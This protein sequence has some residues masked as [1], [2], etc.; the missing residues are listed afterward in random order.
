MKLISSLK[1]IDPDKE[2]LHVVTEEEKTQLQADLFEMMKDVAKICE[3]NDIKWSLSGGS[4]LGAVRHHGFIPWDDDMDI[5]MPRIEFEKFRKVFPGRF[6]DK[7]ELRVPGDKNYIF[8]SPQIMK[9]NTVFKSLM[10]PKNSDQ[11]I[12]I[13]IFLIENLSNTRFKYFIH[14]LQCTALYALQSMVRVYKC[15]DNLL[16]HTTN[17]PKIRRA[18]KFRAFVGMILSIIPLE[19]WGRML[20]N[21]Y[22][23]V[24]DED[25][26]LVAIPSGC[27]HYFGETYKRSKICTFIPGYFETERFP[28]PKGYKYYLTKLYG[29]TYM[30]PPPEAE[31]M[32]HV[33]MEFDLGHGKDN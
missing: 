21:C 22:G 23:K 11:G 30:T 24:K 20:F 6:A 19:K 16:K 8:H 32:H 1:L 4:V 17:Y 18:V 33:A 3:E 28:I 25:S 27:H 5:N 7:Y 10:S 31:Q 26:R 12:F 9:K 29:D 14:G 15:K 2:N 13:D